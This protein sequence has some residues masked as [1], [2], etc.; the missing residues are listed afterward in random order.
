MKILLVDDHAAVRR[1]LETILRDAFPKL[2]ATGVGDGPSAVELVRRK[3]WDFIVLD[4]NLPSRNGIDLIKEILFL[5][6]DARI[7]MMSMHPEREFALRALRAGAGGYLSKESEP[8]ELV[9][10]TRTIL[11][12]RKYITP[13]LA[14]QLADFLARPTAP[15]PHERLSDREQEVLLLIA[16]GQSVKDI[17]DQLHLSAKTVYVHREH[18]MHKMGAAADAELTLYAVRHGLLA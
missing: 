12:G 5:R 6:A 10:A 8:E 9:T 2:E 11:A 1:G 3:P 4:I 7:L 13:A 17:A 16:A 14:E 15:Q 18:I